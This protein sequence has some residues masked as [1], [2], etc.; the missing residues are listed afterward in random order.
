MTETPHTC[1]TFEDYLQYDDGTNKNY[2]FV[3]GKLVGRIL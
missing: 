1:M 2:E 3:D